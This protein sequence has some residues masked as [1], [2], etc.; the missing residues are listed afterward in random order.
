MRSE[1]AAKGDK[2]GSIKMTRQKEDKRYVH[3]GFLC[4]SALKTHVHYVNFV[5]INI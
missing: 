4:L 1:D 2:D 3:T 5:L